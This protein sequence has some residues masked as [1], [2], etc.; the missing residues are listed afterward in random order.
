M[1][2]TPLIPNFTIVYNTNTKENP[3]INGTAW[4]FFFDKKVADERKE[5]LQQQGKFPTLR[6]YFH[7][8]DSSHLGAAERYWVDKHMENQNG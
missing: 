4:E 5:E 8:R 7:S 2:K 1:P 3:C 6:P